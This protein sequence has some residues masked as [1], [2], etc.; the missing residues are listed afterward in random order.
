M[1]V[2]KMVTNEFYKE[3]ESV[4]ELINYVMDSQ[5]T[6]DHYIGGNCILP[7]STIDDVIL[8]F[9]VVKNVWGKNDGVQFIH[10]IVSFSYE[11]N[12]EPRQAYISAYHISTYFDGL[13]QVVYGVHQDTENLH[14]HF[15]VN[16]VSYIDGRKISFGRNDYWNLFSHVWHE[17]SSLRCRMGEAGKR[18]VKLIPTY[19]ELC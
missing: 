18:I 1:A 5:K 9:Q 12:V 19:G 4:P 17:V 8:Q 13:Y 14:I 16:S 10:F 15:L 3:P 6:E 7:G 11:E 2:F